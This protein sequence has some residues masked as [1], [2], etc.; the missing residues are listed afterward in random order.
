MKKIDR[1]AHPFDPFYFEKHTPGGHDHDQKT[2]GTGGAGEDLK[3]RGFY[4]DKPT[5][6]KPD[7]SEAKY[8]SSGKKFPGQCYEKAAQ[9]IALNPEAF[10]GKRKDFKLVHG[11]L[12]DGNMVIGHG[13]VETASGKVFDGTQQKFYDKADY[14]A[15]FR[16][17]VER[18]Y[19]YEESRKMMTKYKH[20]GPWH[21]TAGITKG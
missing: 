13:W 11:T 14:Y 20:Y 5:E 19:T 10:S 18:E 8:T 7:T 21:E 15:K 1:P 2:H 4:A 6:V 17:V 12:S 16:V 3:P 9:Y